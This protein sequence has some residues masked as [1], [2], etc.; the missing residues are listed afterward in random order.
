MNELILIDK[1]DLRCLLE[2]ATSLKLQ[3]NQLDKLIREMR[4]KAL[5]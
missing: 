1:E 3:V 2:V 4:L 5:K